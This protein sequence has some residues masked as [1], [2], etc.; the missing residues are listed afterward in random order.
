MPPVDFTESQWKILRYVNEILQSEE[1]DRFSGLPPPKLF[2]RLEEILGE[3]GTDYT[4]WEMG[5]L[6]GDPAQ[7]KAMCPLLVNSLMRL[8][9]CAAVMA[10]GYIEL[11][12]N[13]MDDVMKIVRKGKHGKE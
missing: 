11:C 1:M 13:R 10:A 6:S 7:A 2:E 4:L 9:V 8:S 5:A 3:A 12:D